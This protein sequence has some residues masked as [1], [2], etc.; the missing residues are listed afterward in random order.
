MA[1]WT[2]PQLAPGDVDVARP[3]GA[4][5]EHHR[6]ER[7]HAAASAAMST[8]MSQP[9]SNATPSAS[10]RSIPPVDQTHFS[11]LKSGIP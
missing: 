4:H 3:L 7:A 2:P 6:V 8:P 10:S 9:V 1:K 11:I 5:R